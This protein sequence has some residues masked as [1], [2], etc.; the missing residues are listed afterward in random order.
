MSKSNATEDDTLTYW[1]TT[2]LFSINRPTEWHLALF[3]DDPADDASG[4]EVST[5]DDTAY[6]RQIISFS[7]VVSGVT[8]NSADIS[9][10]VVVLASASYSISHFAIYDAA[11]AGNM[12]YYGSFGVTKTVIGGEVFSFTTGGIVISE[13]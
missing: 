12:L 5:G 8:S 6:V 7:P 9:F 11:T 2:D 4:T 1:L 3:K 13:D 10:P